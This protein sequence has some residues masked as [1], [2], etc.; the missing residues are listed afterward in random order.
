M[1]YVIQYCHN[2]NSSNCIDLFIINPPLEKVEPKHNNLTLEKVEPK[3]NNPPLQK[4]DPKH[5]NLT[6]QKWIII[7]S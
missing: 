4:V 7:I 5:N 2:N 6:L 1:V 3:H